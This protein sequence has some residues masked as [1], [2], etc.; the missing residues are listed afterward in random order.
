MRGPDPNSP[1]VWKRLVNDHSLMEFLGER[2]QQEQVFKDQLL[3]YIEHS[4]KDK[5]WNIIA[6][7]AITILIRAGVQF[8][9]T[10]LRG[11]RIP[12]A[13]LS[14]A[15]FGSV[16]D[17]PHT[18]GDF[19]LIVE[20]R[21]SGFRNLMDLQEAN[22]RNVNLRGAWLRQTD[23]RRADMTSVQFGKLPYLDVHSV[24][25]SCAFSPDGTAL[26]VG[27]D[28]GV[29]GIQ[30]ERTRTLYGHNDA[31]RSVVYS[32]DGNMLVSG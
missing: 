14:Y 27:L 5:R 21:L 9:G 2:V 26:T 31:V 23:L 3:A 13:D 10:D 8:S 16:E 25:W 12:G 4:K 6:A 15:V 28:D 7:N 30:L 20:T 11:V 1:L 18:R 24:V 22:M 17:S 19:G 29:L 32:P